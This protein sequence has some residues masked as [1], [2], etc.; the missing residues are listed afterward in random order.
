METIRKEVNLMCAS[1]GC[2]RVDDDHGDERHL[3]L[4]NLKDAAQAAGITVPE[5]ARN[6]ELAA[7]LVRSPASG[8]GQARAALQGQMRPVGWPNR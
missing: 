1:C 4:T 6:L 7:G 5:V 2:G 3:T 8:N